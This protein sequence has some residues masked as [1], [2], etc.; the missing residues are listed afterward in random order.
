VTTD[1]HQSGAKLSVV[2]CHVGVSFF[3]CSRWR[4]MVPPSSTQCPSCFKRFASETSV[5][6]HM[7]HPRT[8]CMSSFDFHESMSR[9]NQRTSPSQQHEDEDDGAPHN[10][11]TNNTTGAP[12][13]KTYEESHLS[14][15]DLVQD[16][17]TR[18]MLI[19]TPRRGGKICTTHFLL[20]W[21][22]GSLRGCCAQGSR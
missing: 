20:R 6:R 10:N 17:L 12:S 18:S 21:S 22:G 19:I 5:L 8:S 4:P 7:N 13:A 2:G 3:F 1:Q 16:S 15:L 11:E 14:F 9:S